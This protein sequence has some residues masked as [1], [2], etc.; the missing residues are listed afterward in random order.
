MSRTYVVKTPT[1]DDVVTLYRYLTH[2][3]YDL[4]NCAIKHF[5]EG[6]CKDWVH[7]VKGFKFDGTFDNYLSWVCQEEL[8]SAST[9]YTLDEFCNKLGKRGRILL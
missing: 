8:E 7:N 3:N 2:L 6:E 5:V 9:V 1:L 4:T